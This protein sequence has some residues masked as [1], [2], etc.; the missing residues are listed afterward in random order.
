MLKYTATFS[1][2][3]AGQ[4]YNQINEFVYLGGNVNHNADLSIEVHRRAHSAL[5]SLWEYTLEL[6]DTD[7]ALPS[8]SKSGC[9]EPRYSRQAVRLCHVKPAH[10][11]H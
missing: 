1:V 9:L 3:A 7:R 8:S 2:R 5:C 4:V 10:A 11:Y 6:N